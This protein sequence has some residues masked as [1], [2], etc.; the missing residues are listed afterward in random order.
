MEG[1]QHCSRRDRK[2]RRAA[3]RKELKSNLFSVRRK[4]RGGPGQPRVEGGWDVVGP[5][6]HADAA[7]HCMV[8]GSIG[9]WMDGRACMLC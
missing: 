1:E 7:R 6:L 8:D 9:S 5:A 4:R 3:W 2:K